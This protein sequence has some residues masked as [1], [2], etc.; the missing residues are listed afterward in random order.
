MLQEGQDAPDFT[1]QASDGNDVSLSQF[2]GQTVILYFYPRDN[3]SGCT[4]QACSFR[5]DMNLYTEKAAIIL[6]VSKDSIKSHNNFIEKHNLPF[7]LLS[8]PEKEVL[9]LYGVWQEKTMYGKKAMGVVR[10][11]FVI[12]PEGKIKKIFSKVKVDGHSEKVL[13]SI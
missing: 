9:Q 10:S 1:L 5:D 4:K 11:T 2:K 12:D 7:I 6:G 13:E 3:T 8:D